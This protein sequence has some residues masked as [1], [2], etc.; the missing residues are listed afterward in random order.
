MK[1]SRRETNR[2]FQILEFTDLYGVACNIQKSSLANEHAIWIGCEDAN[3]EVLIP[4]HGWTP[5]PMPEEYVANTRMHLNR[6]QVAALLPILQ[7]FV[8]TGEI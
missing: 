6:E 7:R 3:P 4:G 1:I 2:G 5:V 8:D